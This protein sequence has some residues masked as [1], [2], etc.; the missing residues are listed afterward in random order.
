MSKAQA[1]VVSGTA[2]LPKEVIEEGRMSRLTIELE[3]RTN[4][5]EITDFSCTMISRLGEKI[6]REAL[7]GYE[8]EK[9]IQ[10]AI[11]EIERGFFSVTRK[12]TIAALEDVRLSY[13]KAHK[14]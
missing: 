9:G 7:L 6:L 12:A 11:N 3:L 13:R 5:S 14:P 10:N 8:I 2:R 1:I 4:D